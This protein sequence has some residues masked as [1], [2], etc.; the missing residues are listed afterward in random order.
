MYQIVMLLK[1]DFRAFIS[2]MILTNPTQV[3]QSS[4]TTAMQVP[5][6]RR[7]TYSYLT[8]S[9]DGAEWSALRTGCTLPLGKDPGTH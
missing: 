1:V 4:P 5:R 2:K 6:R 9:L 7:S 3:E 8:S